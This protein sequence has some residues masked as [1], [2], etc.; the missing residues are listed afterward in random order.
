MRVLHSHSAVQRHPPQISA[1]AKLQS[2]I[3]RRLRGLIVA[4]TLLITGLADVQAAT[5]NYHGGDV[6]A[7]AQVVVVYWGQ[8]RA[9]MQDLLDRFYPRLLR[10]PYLSVLSEYSAAGKRLGGAGY[11][12]SVTIL[13]KDN[14]VVDTVTIARE[15]DIHILNGTLPQP[16]PNTV[17]M[18]HM[19]E[20]VGVM[21]GSNLFGVPVG[22]HAGNGFCAYHFAA[23]TV[24]PTPVPLVGV[25]GP[26]I[27]IG[28]MP[29]PLRSGCG[30]ASTWP[31]KATLLASHELVEA[32]TNPD[33]V[34]VEMLPVIGANLQC[35][36]S[37]L[38]V[39]T[40]TPV[41]TG[42][43]IANGISPWAWVSG[44]SQMCNPHEVSDDCKTSVSYETTGT[45]DGRFAV[46]EIF[47]NSQGRC[48][49]PVGA[50][51]P[52]PLIPTPPPPLLTPAA[53]QQC[54]AGCQ[55]AQAQCLDVNDSQR[56]RAR[57]NLQL[58]A[59]NKKCSR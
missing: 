10:S 8:Q 29:D 36:G 58:D 28:V 51:A 22:A 27:R 24:V 23:W 59:C 3:A 21:M 14:R 15:I 40:L 18:V 20:N 30:D 37:R 57:C 6:V 44:K 49:T 1:A 56:T 16:T 5:F 46:S 41:L 42:P 43:P 26:K 11:A 12:G 50:T 17:Y 13:P 31:Q 7:D 38:P 48:I 2:V 35:G 53:R 52:T 55:Q 39:S 19:G 4:S 47:L 9:G 45:A 32:I 34:L 54:L 25:F 33:A